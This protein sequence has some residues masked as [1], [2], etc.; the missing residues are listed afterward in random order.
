MNHLLSPNKVIPGAKY[1]TP[2]AATISSADCLVN[3]LIAPSQLVYVV[4]ENT[5][6]KV[7]L[8]QPYQFSRI[9]SADEWH[10]SIDSVFGTDPWLNRAVAKKKI[11]VFTS[12]FTLVPVAFDSENLRST[13]LKAN[14]A[15]ED[16]SYVFSDAIAGSNIRLLYALSPDIVQQSTIYTGSTIEHALTGLINYL[17]KTTDVSEN[18]ALFVYVQSSSMQVILIRN[19]SL[20]FCNSFNYQS[21]EDFMYH[22]L[23]VC[24]QL[25]LDTEL[26]SLTLMGEVMP[27]STLYNLLVK[28]IRKVQFT[29]PHN[30]F[31]FS[32]DYP[33]PPHFFFNLFCL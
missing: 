25:K 22:L 15:V 27:D 4:A 24:K 10:K 19:K 14:C 21:P 20:H 23:F 12:S 13:L 28:Y 29:K 1:I 33:L 3:I 26:L 8:L 6:K 31:H 30:G 32:D 18:E 17:L 16:E 5:S 7:I 11:G 2:E 9:T